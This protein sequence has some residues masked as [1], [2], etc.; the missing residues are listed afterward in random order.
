H[1]GPRC[2]TAEPRAS[3][4][5]TVSG[6]ASAVTTAPT[7]T[8][9]ATT[10][11][12]TGVVRGTPDPLADG[13]QQIRIDLGRSPRVCPFLVDEEVVDLS[14]DLHVLPQRDRALLRDDHCGPA[15]D[16]GQPVTELL[17]IAHRR[18]QGDHLYLTRQVDDDL[19]PHRAP[20]TV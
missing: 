20:K 5:A 16:L 15:T 6:P 8:T 17:G 19:L 10:T 9:T 13:V 12:G 4:T 2:R 11:V 3:P 14:S 1:L 7:V 18:G